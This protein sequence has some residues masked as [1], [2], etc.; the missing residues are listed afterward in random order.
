MLQ[1]NLF[2]IVAGVAGLAGGWFACLWYTRKGRAELAEWRARAREL[3][4]VLKK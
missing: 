4:D 2:W 3:G 1:G